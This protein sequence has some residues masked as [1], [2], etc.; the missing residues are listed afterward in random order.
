M[1]RDREQVEGNS[2]RIM[3]KGVKYRERETKV[4]RESVN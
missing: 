4:A 2:Y 3:K 1:L